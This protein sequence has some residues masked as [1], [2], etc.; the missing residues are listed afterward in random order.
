MNS[1]ERGNP[2]LANRARLYYSPRVGVITSLFVRKVVRLKRRRGL[3]TSNEASLAALSSLAREVTGL[4]I[5]PECVYFKHAAPPDTSPL[6]RFF[7][8]PVV[9]DPCELVQSELR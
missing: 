7:G 6:E 9:S 4:A 3:C 8:A 2:P 1:Q 5:R